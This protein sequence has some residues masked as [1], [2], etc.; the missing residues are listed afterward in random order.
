MASLRQQKNKENCIK[1]IKKMEE[2]YF[3]ITG[4]EPANDFCFIMDANGIF[5]KLW[6][7]SSFLVNKDI[8]ILEVSKLTNCLDLNINQ[9]EE[10]EEKIFLRALSEGKP[11]YVNQ[12]IDGIT[13]KAVKVG[14]KIYIPD[15]SQTV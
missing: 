8:E 10:S 15:K 13:Y 11:E 12:T 5:E 9:I 6:Q 14:T 2:N 4:Y 7:F 3:R 1:E